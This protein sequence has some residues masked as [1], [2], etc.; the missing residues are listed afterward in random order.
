MSI[1]DKLNTTTGVINQI[2]A[3]ISAVQPEVAAGRILATFI[4]DL[5]KN[6][7][8]ATMTEAQLNAILAGLQVQADAELVQ[9]DI[10]KKQ[11]EADIARG[12]P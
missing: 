9:L 10:E 4:I 12:R 7:H 8:A 2:T 3:L 6:R 5:I 1:T 11:A